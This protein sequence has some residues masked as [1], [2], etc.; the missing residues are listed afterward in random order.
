LLLDD[1]ETTSVLVQEMGRSEHLSEISLSAQRL[2]DREKYKDLSAN[3]SS[4]RGGK[5]DWDTS[6]R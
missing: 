4:E 6:T 1:V 2:D 5:R 3:K